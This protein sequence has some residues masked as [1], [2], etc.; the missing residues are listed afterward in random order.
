MQIKYQSKVA[1]HAHF[2]HAVLPEVTICVAP[3]TN[4]V[5]LNYF[6]SAPL[7]WT[8]QIEYIM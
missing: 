1:P 8:A 2:V 6:D 5:M 4:I 7:L 3:F